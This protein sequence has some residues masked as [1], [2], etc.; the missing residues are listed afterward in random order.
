[1]FSLAALL[2]CAAG[3]LAGAEKGRI[4]PMLRD[5]DE[6]RC[7]GE[8]P[9]HIQGV[10]TDGRTL[11]WSF[12]GAVVRTDLN[13]RVLA[14][15]AVSGHAGDPCFAG[16]KLYVPVGSR[17]NQ[18]PKK[19]NKPEN[20][21]LVLSPELKLLRT[22][23]LPDFKY[24][25]GGIGCRNGHFFV[26]GGRPANRP[27]NTVCEYDANF[28]PLRRHELKFDSEA[29]IQTINFTPRGRCL[30]GCYGIGNFAVELDGKWRIMRRVRP[31]MSVGAIVLD[32]ELCLIA[33]AIP[34]ANGRS[35][36]MV[37]VYRLKSPVPA[38]DR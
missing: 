7:S 37:K 2:F 5:G 3:A 1:M 35:R 17:F 14:K 6:I 18:E 9:G 29:G 26:V 13:G 21:V 24:G 25:A 20:F 10:A 32:E 23:P 19:K 36:A 33:R 12:T 34:T 11:Y 28:K 4:L 16:G 30:L 15:Y 22:V 8:F 27:G 31:G 38:A